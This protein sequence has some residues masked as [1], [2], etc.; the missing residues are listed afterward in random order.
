MCSTEA[1]A[2][3]TLIAPCWRYCLPLSILRLPPSI[4]SLTGKRSEVQRLCRNRFRLAVGNRSG[5][6]IHA[7]DRHRSSEQW[8]VGTDSAR[9]RPTARP[10]R[11]GP[12]ATG[13]TQPDHQCDRSDARRQGGGA[14]TIRQYRERIGGRVGR[15][16]G[17]RSGLDTCDARSPV[18]RL[19]H[20]QTWRFG[21][22]IVDL[23][24]NHPSAQWTLMGRSE[25]STWRHF[26]LHLACPSGRRIVIPAR[27]ALPQVV[28]STKCSALSTAPPESLR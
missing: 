24:I 19:L 3:P 8:R 22:G 11:S 15:G 16:A 17:H 10:G 26:S 18:W 14:T 20:D 27:I 6:Q 21:A 5:L 7:V 28:R 4:A 1:L 25:R 12:A 2:P 23:P 13:T 9:R